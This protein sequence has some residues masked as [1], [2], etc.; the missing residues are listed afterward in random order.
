MDLSIQD[1]PLGLPISQPLTQV[2]SFGPPDTVTINMATSTGQPAL[3]NHVSNQAMTN[4]NVI[5]TN[6]SMANTSTN[7]GASGCPIHHEWV[8]SRLEGHSGCSLGPA[9]IDCQSITLI[10]QQELGVMPLQIQQ[11]NYLN[12]FIEF[13]SKV[14]GGG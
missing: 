14:D 13:D 7:Q 2:S 10:V 1:P 8:W 4:T 11:L 5:T 6:Q 12:V 9:Q 3:T